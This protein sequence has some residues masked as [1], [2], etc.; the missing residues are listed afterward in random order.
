MSKRV[1]NC[2]FSRD[3]LD[4][5]E[6]RS[7]EAWDKAFLEPLGKRRGRPYH[8]LVVFLSSIAVLSMSGNDEDSKHGVERVVSVDGDSYVRGFLPEKTGDNNQ[9]GQTKSETPGSVPERSVAESPSQTQKA[10]EIRNGDNRKKNKSLSITDVLVRDERR[11]VSSGVEV[12]D[13][14]KK[15]SPPERVK[16][17]GDL[18][19]YLR[20]EMDVL[21]IKRKANGALRDATTELW[22][23]R[24]VRRRAKTAFDVA[25]ART[26]AEGAKLEKLETSLAAKYRALHKMAHVPA[27][28]ALFSSLERSSPDDGRIELA[29]ALT[30]EMKIFRK[31]K[32]LVAELQ[33][34]QKQK[35]RIFS[36]ARDRVAVLDKKRDGLQAVLALLEQHLSELRRRK[37]KR[38][39]SKEVW[40]KKLRRLNRAV[41]DIA[42]LAKQES[43][44]FLSLKGDLPRPV[45]GMILSHFGEESVKGT[46]VTVH[47]RG[48]EISAIKGWKVRAPAR[49]VVR[50]AGTVS[51]YHNVVVL[52]HGEGFLS[53]SGRL[54]HLAVKRGQKIKQGDV[55]GEVYHDSNCRRWDC[56]KV[57]F[58]LRRGSVA[59]NPS[60][61]FRSGN[62]KSPSRRRPSPGVNDEQ[63]PAVNVAGR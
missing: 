14:L 20:A 11:E 19:A 48:M 43:R 7:T 10:D 28:R 15:F 56:T 39:R 41:N 63:D 45:P 57:Y 36:K 38:D 50:Y 22:A 42:S 44:S 26:E 16:D 31:Q 47:K 49:G 52:D 33:K 62:R 34:K 35:E 18:E 40:N 23:A 9:E 37:E 1:N 55:L 58:E 17:D 25:A 6:L 61:W 21:D 3:E 29:K 51:G 5:G 2:H 30:W 8:F 12:P 27:K 13:P 59:L 60:G 46:S 4:M 53:V 32:K 54:Q 24:G